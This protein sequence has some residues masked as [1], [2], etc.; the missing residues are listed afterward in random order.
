MDFFTQLNDIHNKS[1]E[2][3]GVLDRKCFLT[4]IK[5][6]LNA[7]DKYKAELSNI[8][9]N[10]KKE[11]KLFKIEINEKNINE[12]LKSLENQYNDLDRLN[13][14]PC[15][16]DER[17]QIIFD[18]LTTKL[19]LTQK[20]IEVIKAMYLLK[21]D[22]NTLKNEILQYTDNGN[23][24][25]ILANICAKLYNYIEN[26]KENIPDISQRLPNYSTKEYNANRSSKNNYSKTYI[27][28]FKTLQD[29][30][31]QL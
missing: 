17:K 30:L 12:F 20:E 4:H 15:L 19:D 22:Y 26:I 23:T 16:V 28:P 10:L 1:K 27:K 6:Y 11:K 24:Y 9:E 7:T 13:Y 8:Y 5:A 25:R 29:F 31:S 2:K 21:V 3:W 18:N 14:T